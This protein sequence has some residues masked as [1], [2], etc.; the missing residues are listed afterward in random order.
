MTNP[1]PS[2]PHSEQPL[3]LLLSLEATREKR[4]WVRFILP[5]LVTRVSWDNG[6]SMVT[7]LVSLVDASADGAAVIMDVRPPRDR[8]C[9]LQFEDAASS[10]GPIP[11]TLLSAE[12]TESVRFLA[13][14]RFNRVQPARD[15]IHHQKERRAWQRVVPRERR[16]VLSWLVN[17]R[18]L[19]VRGEILNISGGGAAVQTDVTPPSE[20]TIRLKV[21]P[22]GKEVGPADCRLVGVCQARNGKVIARFAF[23]DL[24][25]LQLH[26]VAIG[27]LK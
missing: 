18:E 5:H 3:E 12:M 16:A 4:K 24:C 23:V 8:P 1:P 11:A 26:Q 9:M 25:P 27:A 13:K 15:V 14:F 6:H 22:P 20:Q 10:T 7:H 17:G 21:G 19:E 2:S